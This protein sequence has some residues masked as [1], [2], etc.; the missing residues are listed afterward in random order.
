MPDTPA[1]TARHQRYVPVGDRDPGAGLTGDT[2][3]AI[4]DSQETIHKI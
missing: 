2:T 3:I 4:P 1:V